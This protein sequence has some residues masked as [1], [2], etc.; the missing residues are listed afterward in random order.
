MT[1]FIFTKRNANF[2]ILFLIIG[3]FIGTPIDASEL[4]HADNAEMIERKV[5]V[6]I[7]LHAEIADRINTARSI[8]TE[9]MRRNQL[10]VDEIQKTAIKMKYT[11]YN[12]AIVNHRI[13]NNLTL[14]QMIKG[15]SDVIDEKILSYQHG[16]S[17]LQYFIN[18]SEDELKMYRALG[19]L[20]LALLLKD[21][22]QVITDCK[23]EISVDLVELD[24]IDVRAS[25]SIWQDIVADNM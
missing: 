17:R 12:A 21:V 23:T 7:H 20:D 16:L 5:D 10:Y 2:I 8:R 13:R 25:E 11:S 18:R 4:G 6:L 1:N 3:I 15:F 19:R 9:L 14:I 22:N 24:K